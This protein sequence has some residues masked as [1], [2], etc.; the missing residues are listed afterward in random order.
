MSIAQQ[1]EQLQNYPNNASEQFRDQLERARAAR[2]QFS[3][4]PN[5][6]AGMDRSG[7]LVPVPR[8]RMVRTLVGD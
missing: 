4:L 8:P 2:D 3:G 6:I 5:P 7:E 1:V